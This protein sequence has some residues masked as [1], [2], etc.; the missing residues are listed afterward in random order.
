MPCRDEGPPTSP[1][2]PKVVKDKLDRLTHENDLLREIIL[3]AVEQDAILVV[4]KDDLRD[5]TKPRISLEQWA[6]I[7]RSQEDHRKE[8][9]ARLE[10]KLRDSISRKIG[11]YVGVDRIASYAAD[12][13]MKLAAVLLADPNKPLEPQLGF[14]PDS[15]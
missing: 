1:P 2:I 3:D 14:D 11:R 12:D 4:G 9:L 15:L 6:M 13:S 8:D 7:K 10:R 5:L